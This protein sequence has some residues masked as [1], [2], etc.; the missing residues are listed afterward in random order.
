MSSDEDRRAATA[1]LPMHVEKHALHEMH[2]LHT[3][4][5]VHSHVHHNHVCSEAPCA[6]DRIDPRRFCREST[7]TIC[8]LR[9]RPPLGWGVAFGGMTPVLCIET[10]CIVVHKAV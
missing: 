6:K 5:I 4:S 9:I 1:A 8:F 7:P 3:R 2:P 10:L